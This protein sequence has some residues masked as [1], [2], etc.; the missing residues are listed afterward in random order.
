MA[1]STYG[2]SVVPIIRPTRGSRKLVT[3]CVDAHFFATEA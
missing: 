3:A 1:P 2:I